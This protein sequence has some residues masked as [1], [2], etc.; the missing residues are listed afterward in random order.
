MSERKP[1]RRAAGASGKRAS[2]PPPPGVAGSAA[3]PQTGAPQT[4]APPG[5]D[6]APLLDVPALRPAASGEQA[7]P[8]RTRWERPGWERAEREKDWLVRLMGQALLPPLPL[9]LNDPA[10]VRAQEQFWEHYVREA[11]A[12][13]SPEAR[14]RTD[15]EAAA[16]SARVLGQLAEP[17]LSVQRI[18]SRPFERPA[19]ARGRI[20]EVLQTAA[21]LRTAPRLDLG[22]AAGVGR[23][24]WDEECDMW[25]EVPEGV[26]PGRYLALSVT[27]ESMVPLLHPEDVVLVKL[28]PAVVRDT[29]IVARHPEDGYVVKRVGSVSDTHIELRSLNPAF[30][31][32][33]IPRDARLVLGTVVLRWCA[34]GGPASGAAP[35]AGPRA[36]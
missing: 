24:L 3:T 32:V 23:E 2:G 20:A 13:Q 22:V 19:A 30:A 6:P 21:E 12:E 4:G 18:A 27:G 34:H 29:V 9:E 14:L 16:F 31:P 10:L 1:P 28:S 35:P 15:D 5:P 11:R 17:R 8:E 36:S 26:A 7:E 25:V 33:S